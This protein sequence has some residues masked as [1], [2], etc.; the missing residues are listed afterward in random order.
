MLA[1]TDT[2]EYTDKD[3]DITIRTVWGEARNQPP[4][5]WIAVAWVIR[6]RATWDPP[7]W[8][9]HTPADCC[10]KSWQFSSWL[11]NDPNRAKMVALGTD[12]PLYGQI[13]QVV[14]GV[15]QGT[16]TDPTRGCTQYKVNG[17]FASWDKAVDNVDPI[18]VGSHNFWRL[19]PDGH[20]LSLLEV[21]NV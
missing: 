6:R 11:V 12:D 5:G 9:G 21:P 19:S 1:D 14:L 20:V 17:S 3:L 15:F 16:I 13:K 2:I 18:V 7:A 4:I 10:Q 8:W